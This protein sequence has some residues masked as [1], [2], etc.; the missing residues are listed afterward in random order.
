M[1]SKASIAVRVSL[2]KLACLAPLGLHRMRAKL[3]AAPAVFA[4][5]VV[6]VAKTQVVFAFQQA[7]VAIPHR[8]R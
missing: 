8:A 2:G 1:R 6:K 7:K 4:Q 5:V 3:A